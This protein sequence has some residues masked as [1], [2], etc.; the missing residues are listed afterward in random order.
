[1]IRSGSRFTRIPLVLAV[2]LLAAACPSGDVANNGNDEGPGNRFEA[3]LA[4]V[5]PSG[6]T[7]T[8]AVALDDATV[9]VTVTASGLEPGTR[10][11]QHV[12]TWWDCTTIGRVLVNLDTL[13]TV[14]GE[15]PPRGDDYP[16]VDEQGGLAYQATR[17]VAELTEALHTYRGMLFEELDLE[18]RTI[19]I[20]DDAHR[21]IA[22]GEL[23]P[24][25]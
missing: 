19:F 23:E 2:A 14:P 5:G 21:P 17:S 7:G 24:A 20:R 10:I 18:N 16:R 1:M 11:S 13:L 12:N 9:Q 3:V 15:G 6:V 22:C 25:D 4:P 8:A